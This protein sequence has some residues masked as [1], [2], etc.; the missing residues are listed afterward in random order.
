MGVITTSSHPK[1]LWPG[2][3]KFWGLSYNQHKMQVTDLFDMKASTKNY[4]ELVQSTSFGLAP[5][6]PQGQSVLYDSHSQGPVQRAVHDVYAI[7]WIVTQEEIEDNLYGELAMSRTGQAANSMIQTKETVGANVYNRAFNSSYTF[8]DGVELCSTA[9]VNTTGGTWSNELTVGAALSEAAL[10]DITIQIRNAVNDRG[11]KIRLAPKSLIV[12][13]DL[14][15]DAH[16]ILDSALQS[17]TANNDVNVLKSTGVFP[18]GIKVNNYLTDTNNWFVRTDIK[19][20]GL[21]C[22]ERRKIS[23]SKDN[24]FDTGNAKAKA[25]ERYSFTCGDKR[26]IYGSAPA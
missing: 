3:Y 21:I 22:F 18:E 19:D 10:E 26:A 17:G 25:T 12:P 6:K 24:D 1:A 20:G 15:F 8:A 16:R 4:E 5:K 7:G 11:L 23:F 2:V 13:V 14:E 9:N